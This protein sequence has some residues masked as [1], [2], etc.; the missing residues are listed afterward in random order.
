MQ[1]KATR[2]FQHAPH[3]HTPRLHKLE[4]ALESAFPGIEGTPVF[5]SIERRIGADQVN[6]RIWHLS[7]DG[8]VIAVI[9]LVHV[10]ISYQ[11]SVFG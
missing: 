8:E 3:L 1:V 5:A 11:S 2:I 7:K 9:Q 10:V 6:G 4:I